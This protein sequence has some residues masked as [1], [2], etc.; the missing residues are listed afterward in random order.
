MPVQI[1]RER[2]KEL[3]PRLDEALEIVSNEFDGLDAHRQYRNAFSRLLKADPLGRVAMMGTDQ[4]DM[5]VPVLCEAIGA[6]VPASG[7]Q[8]F[9]FGAGDG[10]TFAL[11]ADSVP[12]GTTVSV[13]EPNP[14]YLADYAA[15][16]E[17]HP[18]IHVGAV[19]EAG[20]DEI[21]ETARTSGTTLPADGT[22]DLGLGLHMIYFANDVEGCLAR[23]LRFVRPGG[24]FFNVVA[25]ETTAYGG[26]VLRAFIDAGGDTGD[27]EGALADINHRKRLFAPVEDGGGA[28][29]EVLE[30]AGIQ[31]EF[32]ARRQSSRLYGHSL[33]DMLALSN[34]TTLVGVPGTLKFE[35][36]ARVLRDRPEDVDLRV[37]T[38]GPRCGMWS[39]LQPQWVTILRRVGA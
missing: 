7:G 23:I 35:V 5:F 13:E 19:L 34:I 11:A 6:Y 31:V 8:I 21:D 3:G 9:D 30:A 38:E 12:Q 24:A 16:L 4:R 10:Q 25:D 17:H 36:A 28:M 37:E 29:T 32:S 27:N 20:L 2:A 33:A 1:D 22:I 14:G 26:R 15:F 39:V 18:N